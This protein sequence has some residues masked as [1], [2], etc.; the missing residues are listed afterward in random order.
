MKSYSVANVVLFSLLVSTGAIAGNV[1]VTGTIPSTVELKAQNQNSFAAATSV[2]PRIKQISLQRIELSKEA[3][4]YLAKLVDA[5]PTSASFAA[6][7]AASALPASAELGMNNL[8]VLDQGQHGTCVTFAV[9]GALDAI[10]GNSDYISQLCNLELG[11][12]LESKDKNYPS[13]WEGSFNEIVLDQI[14][15]YGIINM[16]YQKQYGCGSTKVLKAYPLDDENN[17]GSP[18][19]TTEFA[20]HSENIMKDIYVKKLLSADDAFSAKSNMDTVLNNV[21][22]AVVNGHRAVF[23]TLL[24]VTGSYKYING[25]DGTFHNV[26]NDAWIATAKVKSDLKAQKIDAGHAM[27]ITGYDDNAEIIA[28]DGTKHRGVLTLRNSWSADAGDN[29]TY[30][31]SYE[32]FKLLVDEVEEISPTPFN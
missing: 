31:M 13:G 20:K 27:I 8:P 23:G 18:V 6:A 25:A 30:Y 2:K 5:Q 16:S 4:S 11:S 32:F 9:S 12:Y 14:Q 21:K 10:H 29:G 26:K 15:Q 22:Q 19:S 28:S 3:S 1:K 24:D 17:I 7:T